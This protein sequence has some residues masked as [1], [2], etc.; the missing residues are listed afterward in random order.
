MKDYIVFSVKSILNQDDVFEIMQNNLSDFLWRRGDSDAQ[1][2]YVSGE[3]ADGVYLKAWI[4][5]TPFTLTLSFN[6][7]FTKMP[8]QQA[9]KKILFDR[10]S[11]SVLPNLGQL[12]NFRES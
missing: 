11:K 2:F 5:E 1:G 10:I 4:S 9:S 8:T 3:R 6:E 7:L 12:L